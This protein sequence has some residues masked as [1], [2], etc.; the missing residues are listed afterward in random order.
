MATYR[1]ARC[2]EKSDTDEGTCKNGNAL[3]VLDL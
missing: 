3:W 1:C 2:G